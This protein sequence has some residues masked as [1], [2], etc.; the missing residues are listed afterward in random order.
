MKH[1][2]PRL[3]ARM[4]HPLWRPAVLT[5]LGL[6]VGCLSLVLGASGYGKLPFAQVFPSY[7]TSPLLLAL[8]LLPPVLLVWGFALLSRRAWVG[9]LGG[10]LPVVGLSLA[11]FFKIR[12]RSD[13]LMAADLSLAAEAGNIVKKY[14]LD[15]TPVVWLALLALPAGLL[16][17]VWLA[18]R[19]RGDWRERSFA[20]ASCLALLAVA[21]V[22]LYG[23][24]ALYERTATALEIDRWS[25]TDRYVARGCVYPFLH[26]LCP[27]DADAVETWASVELPADADIP[28]DRRV[29][30]MGIMLE[31]F[32]DLTDFDALAAQ[33]AV[34][35]VYVPWHWLEERSVSGNLLTNIFAGGTIATEREFLTGL[36]GDIEFASAVD[37]YVWYLRGQGYQTFGSHPSHAW[38]YDRENVNRYMGFEEYWFGTDHYAQ[39]VDPEAAT[40]ASSGSDEILVRELAAQLA[41]RVQDGPCFSFSV[42]AQNHGPYIQD[43][44]EGET[45][46]TPETSG[47]DQETCNVFNNYLTGI[48]GTIR[49]VL[50]LTRRLEAMEEPVVLVLFGDHKPWAGNGNS[51]YAAVG[52]DFNLSTP[53]GFYDYYATPYVIWANAAAKAVLEEDFTGDGGDFSPC[54]LMNK[55]FDLCSWEGPGYMAMARRA[56]AVTPL[57]H[58]LGLYWYDGAVTD[59]LPPERAGPVQAFLAAQQERRTEFDPDAG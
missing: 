36:T 25:V 11:N 54:F 18:P 22:S 28:E 30:I 48:S 5:G 16:L 13:P 23:S 50:W 20:G 7:W 41:D 45:F 56:Q 34:A 19:D 57:L 24:P 9:F 59:Q 52:A 12:L 32:C 10:Y 44:T 42:T 3:S 37:S 49:N 21:A 8:N 46:L 17:A 4:D 33:E 26:S 51:A 58:N 29:S 55:V 39:W 14:T 53:E 27:R 43:Y 6:A 40:W 47:L 2:S 31:A 1:S 38:F 15:L 35:R